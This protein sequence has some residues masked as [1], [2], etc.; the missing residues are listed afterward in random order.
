[1]KNFNDKE[2]EVIITDRKIKAAALFL[3]SAILVCTPANSVLNA[4]HDEKAAYSWYM[5]RAK[6]H[7]QPVCE[8]SMSFIDGYDVYYIDK[9]SAEDGE[10]VLYLTFD[11]GYENGNIARILDT[12]KSENVPGTF[13]ILKNLIEHDPEL[14]KR[15]AD[16][17]HTVGNHTMRHRDMTKFTDKALFNEEL[18]GLASMYLELTGRE[19]AKYYRPPEGRFSELNLKYAMEL[20]YDTILWSFAY[21]DWDNNKQPSREEAMEKLRRNTHD[22]AV[23]LLHPTSQTNA[24]VLGDMIREW[25]TQGY[26]FGTPEELTAR[27]SK[28]QNERETAD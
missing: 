14:V 10:K 11:A 28:T 13:F 15:M 26:R 23:I 8:S 24:E 19:M 12:L 4:A 16:E 21:A 9:K 2:S 5:K 3:C 22:G 7:A 20:G 6:D 17:G 18:N 25:K 27:N 1:V